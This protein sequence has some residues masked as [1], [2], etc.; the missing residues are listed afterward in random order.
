MEIFTGRTTVV[1]FGNGRSVTQAAARQLRNIHQDRAP[2]RLP[3]PVPG[4]LDE[5]LPCQ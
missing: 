3:P 5:K 1:I 2:S 4:S